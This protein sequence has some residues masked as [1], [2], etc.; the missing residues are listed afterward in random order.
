MAEAWK[1]FVVWHIVWFGLWDISWSSFKDNDPL[2]RVQIDLIQCVYLALSWCAVISKITSLQW[3]FAISY[4]CL[5]LEDNELDSVLLLLFW[6]PPA[7][8]VCGSVISRYQTSR[9]Y[10]STL[11][12]I[13]LI[14]DKTRASFHLH[15]CCCCCPGLWTFWRCAWVHCVKK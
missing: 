3:R 12:F 6:F 11:I 5:I 14:S 10:L 13:Y 7:C 8:S 15:M 9:I 4:H 2:C 1:S